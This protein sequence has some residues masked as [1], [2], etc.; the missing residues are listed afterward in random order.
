MLPSAGEMAYTWSMESITRIVGDLTQSERQVYE[1]VLGHE[2]RAGQTVLVQ[3]I[4]VD[5]ADNGQEAKP[6]VSVDRTSTEA[7]GQDNGDPLQLPEWCDVFRG[8]SDEEVD[9]V[10]QSILSRCQSTRN[11]DRDL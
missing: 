1:T 4:D 9:A 11:V 6:V 7:P 8:L 10:E 2:L 5:T 3:L